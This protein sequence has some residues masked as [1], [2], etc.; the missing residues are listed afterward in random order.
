MGA[1]QIIKKT[2]WLNLLSHTATL[3]TLKHRA[4]RFSTQQHTQNQK[5]STLNTETQNNTR[6]NPPA[7]RISDHSQQDVVDIVSFIAANQALLSP[8]GTC[9]GQKRCGTVR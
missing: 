7:T 4:L 1:R 5:D 8:I 9:P 6:L 3:N 2:G